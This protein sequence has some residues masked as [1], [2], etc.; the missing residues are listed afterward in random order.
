MASGWCPST[1][2][3][4]ASGLL[5]EFDHRISRLVEFKLLILNTISRVFAWV[6]A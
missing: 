4:F 2:D 3:G 1:G 6:A 5:K